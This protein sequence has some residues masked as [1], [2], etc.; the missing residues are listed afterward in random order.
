MRKIYILTPIIILLIVASNIYY[1]FNIYELQVDFQKNFLLK[2]TQ[3]S[4]YEIEQT[5][6]TFTSDLNFILFSGKMNRF[7]VDE[8]VQQDI[9]KKF[10]VFYSKYR[11]LVTSITYY[12]DTRHVFSLYKDPKNKFIA[13]V[14][15]AHNQRE[16]LTRDQILVKDNTFQYVLPVFAGRRVSGNVLVSLDYIH[17]I[18]SVLEKSH[19][20]NT[21]WQW[22]LNNKGHIIYNNLG[23]DRLQIFDQ[24]KIADEIIDGFQGALKHKVS[25]EGKESDVISAYYPT[26]FLNRDF[27]IVFSL[28]NDV[29]LNAI[30]KNA[31]TIASLTLILIALIITV[32]FLMLQRKKSEEERL[33]SSEANLKKILANIPIG[34]MVLAESHHILFIN[35]NA[36]STFSITGDK[37]E[38]G[39]VIGDWFFTGNKKQIEG[40]LGTIADTSNFLYLEKDNTEWVLLR[41]EIP[42]LFEG[43]QATLEALIDVT[44]LEKARRQEAA[45]VKAK[46][47]LLVNMSQEIRVPLGNIIDKASTLLRSSEVKPDEKFI[48]DIRYSADLL[49]SIVDDILEF[50]KIEAGKMMLEEIP[51][52]LRQELKMVFKSLKPVAIDKKLSFQT[53]FDENVKDH[54]I[55]DPFKIRQ[56]LTKLID[57]ALKHT[58]AGKVEVRVSQTEEIYG[59]LHLQFDIEDTGIGLTKEQL[60]L[61]NKKKV[62]PFLK[63]NG[64]KKK[65]ITGSGLG[66]S[67]TIQLLDMLN[68]DIQFI[69]PVRGK[70]KGETPGTLVR[71][72]IPVF[73]NEKLKKDTYLDQITS[74]KQIKALIIKNNDEPNNYIQQQLKQ[75]GVQAIVNFKMD[76]IIHL[77][78]ANAAHPEQKYHLLIIKDSPTFDGFELIQ[79]LYDRKLTTKYL[80][81][82]TSSNDRKGNYVRARKLGIDYYLI[83]PVQGSELFNIIQDN[84]N[85]IVMEDVSPKALDTISRDLKILIAEDNQ[86]NQ[87]VMQVYFKNLGFEVDIADDGST[88]VEK[89]KKNQYDIIF[90]DVMMPIKDGWEATRDLRN[91]GIDIPI[92][93]VTADVSEETRLRSMESS[94]N[95]YIPKPVKIDDIKRVLIK[96]FSVN[97]Q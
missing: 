11:D 31:I 13:N 34:I 29:I 97:K 21:Q 57:N 92:I 1:Y 53:V 30:I 14:F 50:S 39:N 27:G 37:L 68:G 70:K 88:A 56:V 46:T 75:F 7:F 84:F 22:I 96:H 69:S 95:D 19:L 38:E 48:K 20:G 87:K 83:E 5:S 12:D 60:E 44:P 2:Q 54:F 58:T 51:F 8:K 9:S 49:L 32:F 89:A 36:R 35:E 85:A 42:I 74:Y 10:E 43:K 62:E 26:H 73:S 63:T 25:I 47:E 82:L 16:L 90:M 61:F 15:T 40:T 23:V 78:E 41:E 81:I 3:I 94:M 86:I 77:L 65:N 59:K 18:A 24:G 67:I 6:S 45:A 79:E 66:I 72:K 52:R 80:I 76:K 71:V 64:K 33:K 28:Q 55:G 93:A 4:G 17:Y 91:E